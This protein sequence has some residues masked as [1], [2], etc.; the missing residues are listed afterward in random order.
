MRKVAFKHGAVQG[1]NFFN[2]ECRKFFEQV[3][4]LNA[5]FSDYADIIPSGFVVPGL[6][7]VE[8][9]ELAEGVGREHYARKLVVRNHYFRPVH[10]GRHN[11]AQRMPAEIENAAL[12]HFIAVVYVEPEILLY[13]REGLC[14]AN[15]LHVGVFL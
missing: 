3:L 1:A 10:E 5:V 14:V 4:H 11:K 7:Y 6:V 15:H 2:V 9:A 13:H 8:R 12:F